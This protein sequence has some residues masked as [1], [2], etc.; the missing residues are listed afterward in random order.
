MLREEAE[1]ALRDL[2]KARPALAV[3]VETATRQ[4][5]EAA[6][7]F[8]TFS[9]RLARGTRHGADDLTPA[10]AQLLAQAR[11]ERDAANAVLSRVQRE[12]QNVDW[13]I[14]LRRAEIDQLARVEDPPVEGRG[15]LY[16]IAKRPKPPGFDVVSDNIEFPGNKPPPDNSAA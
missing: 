1:M 10:I 11:R 14:E 15:P 4:A 13:G 5:F 12:L 9:L 2:L 16:E 7:H 6:K 8:E 3:A